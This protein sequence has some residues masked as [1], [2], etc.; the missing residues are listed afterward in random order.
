MKNQGHVL[1]VG[2][3]MAGEQGPGK[4]IPVTE[5]RY[6]SLI[7]KVYDL[8]NLFEAWKEVKRNKGA[9]G[10]DRVTISRFEANLE[11][12]LKM[13]HER[14]RAG[15]YTPPPVRRVYIDKADGS[16]RPLGIPTV[17]DRVV[18]QAVRRVLTP[19]FEAVFLPCS[20]GFRKGFSTRSAIVMVEEY[21][22]QGF[23]WV[24]DVDFKAYFDT[25]D[26]EVLMAKVKE[27]VTDGSILRL[28]RSW[29]TAG[30]MSDGNLTYQTTGTPQGGVISPLLANIYLHSLDLALTKWG[31]KVVRYADD[32][33][34]LCQTQNKAKTE[35]GLLKQLA[36]GELRLTLHPEKTRITRFYN[37]FDFLGFTFKR[38]HRVARRRALDKFKEKVRELTPRQTHLTVR[39]VIAQLN[40]VIRGWGNYFKM[41]HMKGR[42][43]SLDQ[44]IRMRIRSLVLKRKAHRSRVASS[45]LP[46]RRLADLGLVSLLTL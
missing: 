40:P 30:V 9:A 17:A 37:G 1:V 45:V 25:L 20:H 14:L 19:I 18:Q 8:R 35:L 34:V 21:R 22:R 31:Y 43:E 26:H 10:I 41:G 24:V 13:L 4:V 16:K 38:Q 6:Y 3:G 29:L 2:D 7:D 32:L 46:N 44:W 23:R 5:R 39:E 15:T 33:V 27:K 28:I 11:R 42:F 12:Y 36:E